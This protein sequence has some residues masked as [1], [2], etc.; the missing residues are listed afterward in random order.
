MLPIYAELLSGSGPQAG[1]PSRAW[2]LADRVAE[3]RSSR[4]AALGAPLLSGLRELTLLEMG[5]AASLA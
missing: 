5:Y 4:A 3:L 2:G 1:Q